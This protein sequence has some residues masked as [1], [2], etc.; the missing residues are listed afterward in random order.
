M[1]LEW[2]LVTYKKQLKSSLSI[3]SRDRTIKLA[4]L[5]GQWMEDPSSLLSSQVFQSRSP[6]EKYNQY[7]IDR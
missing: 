4:L 5:S 6:P 1:F 7:E 3:L 2:I